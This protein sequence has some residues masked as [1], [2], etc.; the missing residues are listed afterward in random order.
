MK[1]IISVSIIT[2]SLFIF[3]RFSFQSDNTKTPLEKYSQVKINI[4]SQADMQALIQNDITVEHYRGNFNEGITVVINQSE[5]ES[6]RKTGLQYSVEIPD[7]DEY[8]KNRPIP[9]G[10]DMMLSGQI[11]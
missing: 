2:I 4:R 5:I 7:M 9:S 11:Q 8:Y 3:A 6:L 1:T 10:T